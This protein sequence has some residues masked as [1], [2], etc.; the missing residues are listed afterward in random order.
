MLLITLF[1]LASSLQLIDS[2][3]VMG[4]AVSGRCR[5]SYLHMMAR[6]PIIAGN[7]KM[8]TELTSAVAL[9]TE[10]AALTKNV[11]PNRVEIVL[12]PPFVFLSDVMKV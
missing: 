3:N 11:D 5:S 6:K 8:N 7:W 2:F 9:A 4:V 10:V 12:A 1:I